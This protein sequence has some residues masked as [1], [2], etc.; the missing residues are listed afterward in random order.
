MGTRLSIFI[1]GIILARLLSPSDFGLVAMLGVFFGISSSLVDSGFTNAL[2]REKEITVKDKNTVFSINLIISIVLYIL[3]W[4]GAPAIAVFFD[5]P[6]LLWLT[7]IMGLEIIFKALS[8]VQRAVLMQS[9]RFKLLSAIDVGVSILTGVI[10]IV[11][12]YRGMGVW[13]LAIKFFLSSLLVSI[14]FFW[15][16][17]WFPSGFINRNSFD[18]LFGFGS[19][20]LFTGLLN[21][22]YSNIYNLI[23][24]KFFPPAVLGFYNRAYA[25]TSQTTST[26]LISLGQVTYPILSKT[27]DDPKRMKA[28]YRKIIMTITFINFPLA[29]ILG[30]VAKPFI[31][32]L[33]GEKWIETV[34]FMHLLCISA[35]VTHLSAIN[36]NLFKV[37]GRSDIF[38]K[39][40]V[41]NKIFTTIAIVIGFQFGI[42][43]LVMG[44]V[45]SQYA[46]VYLSMYYSSKYIEYPFME[47]FK[48]IFPIGLLLLP[49]ILVMIALMYI[50]FNSNL[51]KLFTMVTLG[52][53]AYLLSAYLSKS[54]ALSQINELILPFIKKRVLF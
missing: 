1:V 18:R 14:I 50:D 48:D 21:I 40:S 17:P 35:L 23:I 33:L 5:Q 42:W 27:R 28:A 38:L 43:G 34:P 49:L 2:I 30:F 7:R 12:A 22:F 39:I 6:Q 4:F 10:A 54:L 45:I 51:L 13:A 36:K 37:I 11:L 8:I 16:N 26:V 9:L 46:D 29:T 52:G 44:S 31:L 41:I 19:K 25:F 53:G 32:V 47:Q 20:L 3:L 24:G 15:V